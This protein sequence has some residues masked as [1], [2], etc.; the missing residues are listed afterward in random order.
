M[1]RHRPSAAYGHHVQDIG[2]G[3]YIISWTYDR[4]YQGSRL[5]WPTT[6]KRVT[7]RAG[8]IRFAKRWRIR[9]HVPASIAADI[10]AV[11]PQ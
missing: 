10:P 3:N 9:H 11:F 6:L 2:H 1:S 5:R 4:Y 8:A 7:D